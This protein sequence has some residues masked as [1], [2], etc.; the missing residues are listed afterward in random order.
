MLASGA[1][2]LVWEVTGPWS[3]KPSSPCHVP[4]AG[5]ATILLFLA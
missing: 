4:E 2:S 5:V 1:E 3:L